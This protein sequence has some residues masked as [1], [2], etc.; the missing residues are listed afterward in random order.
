MNVQQFGRR[1]VFLQAGLL[2][3]NSLDSLLKNVSLANSLFQKAQFSHSENGRILASS[4]N[5]AGEKA[6]RGSFGT[7][8][9]REQQT[10]FQLVSL[11]PLV[12]ERQ[13]LA[14]IEQACF[15]I[16]S[17]TA[18]S[19]RLE[20]E[21]LLRLAGRR[22]IKESLEILSLKEGKEQEAVLIGIGFDQKQLRKE[23]QNLGQRL[24]LRLRNGLFEKNFAKNKNLVLKS[25]GISP[26]QISSFESRNEK[27]AI[28]SLVI[29]K[30]ALVALEE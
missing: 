25:Y 20:F 14:A 1:F 28:E 18:I 24:G 26:R 21:L 4:Q 9:L 29:E 11:S 6:G 8:S 3:I 19:N 2:N 22:Q 27:D 23:A 12:S 17:K 30:M 15:A 7:S 13:V 16:D 5:R 10:V